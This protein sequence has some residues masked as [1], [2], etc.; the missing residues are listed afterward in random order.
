[1]AT[2]TETKTVIRRKT[3]AV[4]FGFG[5]TLAISDTT[6]KP[7]EWYDDTPQDK[8]YVRDKVSY[9][10]L[11]SLILAQDYFGCLTFRCS[12]AKVEWV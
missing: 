4:I 7:R 12:A 6:K 9:T 2:G 1:M 3:S 11:F 10:A 5:G 8:F